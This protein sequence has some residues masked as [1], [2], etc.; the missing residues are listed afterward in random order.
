MPIHDLK[1][2]VFVPV[3]HTDTE[4][5]ERARQTVR[6]VKPDVVAVE[7]DKERYN[8]LMNQDLEEHDMP[9][10]MFGD[11]TQNMMNQIALLL[12][13][14]GQQTGAGV[15]QEM[16]AAIEEGRSIG[17]KIA[18][19][20]RP[21]QE[22]IYAVSQVPLDEIYK[23]TYSVPDANEDLQNMGA[24]GFLSMLKDKETVDELLIEFR[25]ELPKLAEALI[26]QRDEYVATALHTILNDVEGKIVAVLG[27]GH[28]EGV[29]RA[30]RKKL[31]SDA[32]A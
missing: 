12:R 4:S 19:V 13:S 16:L 29:K 10:E 30:L 5:I 26:D 1:R 15:G 6:D 32:A 11:P 8:Q 27:A 9:T 22:T 18:L 17:S 23:I 20:D 24:Q 7:L 14:F 2:I 3:I 21:I 28:I 25:K 31:S